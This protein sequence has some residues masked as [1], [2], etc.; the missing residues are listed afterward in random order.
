MSMVEVT[1]ELAGSVSYLVGAEGF[2]P[3][4]GWPYQKDS[5]LIDEQESDMDDRTVRET[6]R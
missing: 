5:R 4:S 3:M 2:E 1:T 6:N